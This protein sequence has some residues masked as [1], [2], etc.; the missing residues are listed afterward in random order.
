[1][2]HQS[3][4]VERGDRLGAQKFA[5]R[6]AHHAHRHVRRDLPQHLRHQLAALIDLGD[7]A[8]RVQALIEADCGAR[9]VEGA[10]SLRR[11]S[12]STKAR[13]SSARPAATMPQASARRRWSPA[14]RPRRR[15]GERRRLSARGIEARVARARRGGPRSARRRAPAG[16]AACPDSGRRSALRNDGARLAAFAS[17]RARLM[18]VAGSA[19][20]RFSSG[21]GR[22]VVVTTW[23]GRSPRRRQNCSMSQASAA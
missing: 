12:A 6:R 4:L 23:R 2:R 10:A 14:G 19:S 7:D 22:G 3:A 11:A 13:P 8:V 20:R 15:C 17:V 21:I 1:M 18:A 9:P 16:R 5:A